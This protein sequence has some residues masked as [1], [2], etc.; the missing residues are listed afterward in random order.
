[1]DN[2]HSDEPIHGAKWAVLV[3][4]LTPLIGIGYAINQYF[5]D[6]I[7]WAELAVCA[8]F[9]TLCC[10]GITCGFHRMLTHQSFTAIKP[11]KAFITVLG[12]MAGQGPPAFWIG[13]H[14]K[15][16]QASDR[17]GDPHSPHTHGVGPIS[18]LRGF[19][20]GH[21]GWLITDDFP[22]FIHLAKDIQQD[23]VV[24][25]IN[26]YYIVWFAAGLI[27]PILMTGGL[28]VAFDL[29]EGF[30]QGCLRGLI[31][32]TLIRV[33]LVHHVTWSVNSICHIWGSQPWDSK[34]ESRN[35]YLF[36]LLALGEGFHNAHH[37][38]PSSARHGLRWWEFDFTWTMIVI[39]EKLGWA[40]QVKLPNARAL[41]KKAQNGNKKAA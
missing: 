4:V 19:I 35:N 39:F 25:P 26:K 30:A 29:G 31:W 8:L 15:H 10:F 17:D 14:R 5:G 27:I 1:M 11:L 33:F 28:Y 22:N 13:T 41:S 9:Y 34:D 40:S 6:K 23:E 32:G 12:C 24:K 2:Q 18:S 36:G 37:A 21:I 20:H 3:T 7:L 38:F 16:H